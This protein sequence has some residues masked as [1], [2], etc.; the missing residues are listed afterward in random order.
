MKPQILSEMLR[1]IKR[2]N[3]SASEKEIADMCRE[4]V[5]IDAELQE[6][7]F[8]YWFANSSNLFTVVQ[9]RPGETI[10]QRNTRKPS[11]E[12]VARKSQLVAQVKGRIVAKLMEFALSDGTELR[13]AT[14]GQCKLEGNWLAAVGERGK[15]NEIVGK[16]LTETDLQNLMKRFTSKKR[17]A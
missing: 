16:K 6:A 7:L 3:P 9:V 10:V 17:A 11:P 5:R 14:F 4:K 13:H 2:D 12:S 15:A 8:D 1:T